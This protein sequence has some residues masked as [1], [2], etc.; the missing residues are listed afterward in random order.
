MI[1]NGH[2]RDIC[3]DIGIACIALLLALP[4][5][6]LAAMGSAAWAEDLRYLRIGTG[7]PGE[8]YFPVGGLIASALSNPPGAPPCEKGGSCG[9]PN[10]IAV[11]SV[12]SG[13]LANIEAIRDGRLDAALVQSDVVSWAVRGQPPF[14]GQP[15]VTLRSI[16]NLYPSQL[17]LVA[18][19]EARIKGPEDLKGKRVSLGEAGS[20]TL[21]H[22]RQFL[23]AWKIKES[24]VGAQFLRSA[25]ASDAMTAGTLDAFFV[26]D[27][28]PVPTVTELSRRM[29]IRLVPI[30]GAGSER[31][32]K[33]NPLLASSHIPGGLYEG[34]PD[35][36]ATVQLD[37]SLVTA[38][39]VPDAL[40]E[41]M[42]R[43]LW[44]PAT[45]A[46]LAESLSQAGKIKLSTALFGLGAPL[47]AG[48][49]R[50]YRV[51][52]LFP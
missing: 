29:P 6:L 37:I 16:A 40:V 3:R 2:R 31:L 28:A 18:R 36:V 39:D 9:V 35:D 1:D 49:E 12:T 20:G 19:A 8:S 42:T 51:K 45:T 10:L 23:A 30:D 7:P 34:V 33:A 5:I 25:L 41:N 11:A 15:V 24:D 22:A 17:H 52:G 26:I 50:Y 48:A 32:M 4:A 46:L 27:R 13:S 47:H 14:Q 44:H 43:A 38:S 21:L